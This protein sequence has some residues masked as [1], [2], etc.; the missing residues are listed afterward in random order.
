[1]HERKFHQQSFSSKGA[2]SWWLVFREDRLE[3]QERWTLSPEGEG[4][5]RYEVAGFL[6]PASKVPIVNHR[7]P[8]AAFETDTHRSASAPGTAQSAPQETF[9]VS[10]ELG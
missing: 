2:L 10:S 4:I 9:A 7:P 3:V 1:M 5:E 6:E 8:G